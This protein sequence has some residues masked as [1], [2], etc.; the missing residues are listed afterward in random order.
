MPIWNFERPPAKR[1]ASLPGGGGKLVPALMAAAPDSGLR[2]GHLILNVVGVSIWD[3]LLGLAPVTC[4]VTATL[5]LLCISAP[6]SK[7]SCWYRE[8]ALP[9]LYRLPNN[10]IFWYPNDSFLSRFYIYNLHYLYFISVRII[11]WDCCQNIGINT[12]SIVECIYR[13]TQYNTTI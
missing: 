8:A 11:F 9:S 2:S 13:F 1:G 5:P 7:S 10:V 3:L 6:R 4:L 12:V